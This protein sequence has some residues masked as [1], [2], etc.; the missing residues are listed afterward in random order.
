M[1]ASGSSSELSSHQMAIRSHP[2][3]QKMPANGISSELSAHQMAR[4]G[5]I[6]HSR[7]HLCPRASSLSFS[8]L[9]SPLRP[10]FSGLLG[11][12]NPRYFIYF[13]AVTD[14]GP[15]VLQ[16]TGTSIPGVHLLALPEVR[17]RPWLLRR[18][19]GDG[20]GGR[21]VRSPCLPSW[22]GLR[23]YAVH[24]MLSLC[25]LYSNSPLSSRPQPLGRV[26]DDT[27]CE[28]TREDFGLFV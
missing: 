28:D 9:V 25:S 21:F 26:G 13:Y 18:P 4:P 6:A 12:G 11:R 5:A 24:Q 10:S 8:S 2:G 7:A 19:R 27:P 22:R 14:A 20:N 3:V 23:L 1:P 15:L 16:F 17:K